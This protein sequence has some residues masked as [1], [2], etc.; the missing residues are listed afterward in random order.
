LTRRG[1]LRIEPERWHRNTKRREFITL[2]GGAAAWP[3]AARGQEPGRTYRLGALSASP[4]DAAQHVAFFDALRRLGFVEGQNL[5]VDTDGYGLSPERV[6]TH[7][8]ALVKERVD[9]IVAGGR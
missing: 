8:A 6:A 5:A 1:A 7:A 9:V 4:R 2:L 3:I